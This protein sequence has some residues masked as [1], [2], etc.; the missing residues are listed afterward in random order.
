MFVLLV[1]D[2]ISLASMLVFRSREI[3]VIVTPSPS[4]IFSERVT[5]ILT[6]TWGMTLIAS[7]KNRFPQKRKVQT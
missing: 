7:G 6:L 3:R 4:G 5:A 1:P 2:D